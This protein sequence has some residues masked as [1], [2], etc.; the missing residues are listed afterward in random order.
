MLGKQFTSTTGC[1]K[2]SRSNQT[3][4]DSQK[5]DHCDREDLYKKMKESYD[6]H[7]IDLAYKLGI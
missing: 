6:D 1:D 4:T 7:K 2:Q 5:S 3:D